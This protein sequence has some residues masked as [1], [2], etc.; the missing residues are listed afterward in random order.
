MNLFRWLFR[1]KA[2]E[3]PPG[4]GEA[5]LRPIQSDQKDKMVIDI[6]GLSS[7]GR[8][9]VYEKIAK[10]TGFPMHGGRVEH[11]YSRNAVSRTNRCPRCNGQTRQQ[12]AD[13]IYATDIAPRVMFAPA[14]F[15]CGDCP[16]VIVDEAMIASGVKREFTFQ[17]VV[18][19]D[20]GRKREPD[21]F[22]TWNGKKSVY[23]LDE[24]GNPLGISTHDE[25]DVH[26]GRAR[27]SGAQKSSAK[28]KRK[29]AREDRKQ[30]RRR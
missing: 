5:S 29:R 7:D 20:H 28:R 11:A 21:L 16:T 4:G 6:D 3:K 2:K 13:F 1:R 9:A 30:N 25:V 27:I 10:S 26:S 15:F 14:G 8:E 18:G 23:V 24:D 12:S 17:G 22:R 19:I